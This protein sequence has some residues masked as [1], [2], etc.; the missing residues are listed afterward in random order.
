MIKNEKHHLEQLLL[1][2]PVEI[3]CIDK[4]SSVY[5]SK[6]DGHRVPVIWSGVYDNYRA[7]RLALLQARSNNWDCYNTINPSRI[8][9]ANLPLEPFKRTTKD[10]DI[11]EICT[12]FFDFDPVRETGAS[13]TSEQVSASVEKAG[14]LSDF[15]DDE[16]WGVPVVGFSGNGCHLMYRTKMS[17]E[18][19]PKMKG[20]YKALALRFTDDEVDFDVT[21]K[22]PARIART[23]GT[24]NNKA[25]TLSSC[26]STE[27][28]TDAAVIIATMDRITP[29]QVKKTWVKVEGASESGGSYIKNWDIVGAFSSRGLLVGDGHEPGKHLVTCPWEHEHTSKGHGEVAIWQGEWP[30]FNCLHSHCADRDV[31][32]VLELFGDKK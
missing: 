14:Q 16:G 12:L 26:A 8:P 10:S 4:S 25:G 11:T 30:Q 32:D 28:H 15:L 20:F 19:K 6:G 2:G 23:Y 27:D 22:N 24:V 3:R 29:A 13:A 18:V 1:N 21:V 17:I 31:A 9:A 7:M 5:L